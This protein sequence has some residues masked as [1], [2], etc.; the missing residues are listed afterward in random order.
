MAQKVDF[1]FVNALD[2]AEPTVVQAARLLERERIIKVI[3]VGPGQEKP[4]TPMLLV[5]KREH[6]ERAAVLNA[7]H[8][9][10]DTQPNVILR[11]DKEVPTMSEEYAKIRGFTPEE[12]QASLKPWIAQGRAAARI[13]TERVA[14]ASMISR[15]QKVRDSTKIYLR[16]V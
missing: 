15:C 5:I 14:K 12:I 13:E 16:I 9:L 2:L 1:I 4:T 6:M 8:T 11:D 7:L 3:P 10:L